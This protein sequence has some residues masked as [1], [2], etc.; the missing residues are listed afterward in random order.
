VLQERAHPVP[1]GDGSWSD[2]LDVDVSIIHE[3]EMALLS[4]FQ[5]LVGHFKLAARSILRHCFREKLAKRRGSG[6]VTVNVDDFLSVVHI[7]SL[8]IA[9]IGFRKAIG[10]RVSSCRRRPASRFF[11][12]ELNAKKGFPSGRRRND[13]T[14]ALT[15]L[16]CYFCQ[17]MT[18]TRKDLILLRRG[19]LVL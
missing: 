9:A 3:L 10:Y 18:P 16:R 13:G 11:A 17:A 4:V 14:A 7:A 2:Q 19:N 1:H 12:C 5:L 15:H 6:H 8:F